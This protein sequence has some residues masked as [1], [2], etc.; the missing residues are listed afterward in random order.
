MTKKG[1]IAD[2]SATRPNVSASIDVPDHRCGKS[3]MPRV[4][5]AAFFAGLRVIREIWLILLAQALRLGKK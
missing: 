4:I 2:V 1:L 5:F 3:V